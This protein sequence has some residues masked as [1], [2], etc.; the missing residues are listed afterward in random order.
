MDVLYGQV[1]IKF[2]KLYASKLISIIHL[3]DRH[4]HWSNGRYDSAGHT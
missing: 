4:A 3:G 1:M 2:A